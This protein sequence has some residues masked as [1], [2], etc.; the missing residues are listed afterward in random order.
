MISGIWDLFSF[1][2]HDSIEFLIQVVTAA[3]KYRG[4]AQFHSLIDREHEGCDGTISLT[5]HGDDNQGHWIRHQLLICFLESHLM[6]KFN[7]TG[8]Y[9]FVAW[10]ASMVVFV[11][12]LLWAFSPRSV[13]NAIGITYYP[14]RYYAIALPAYMI[15]LLFLVN[16]AYIGINLMM[17][18]EPDDMCTIRDSQTR[19]SPNVFLKCSTVGGN[20][21]PYTVWFVDAALTI[22][23]I[24]ICVYCL[25]IRNTWYWW[26]R[27]YRSELPYIQPEWEEISL[28]C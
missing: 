23:L 17:T 3:N 16:M 15:V 4:S 7:A 22:C 9:A 12:F 28:H 19:R 24:L 21:F 6:A 5:M 25:P 20:F 8:V 10:I 13:L 18:L 14:S 11:V 27:P 26:H 1:S 2:K